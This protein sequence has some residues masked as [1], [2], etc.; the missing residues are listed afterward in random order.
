MNIF[1]CSGQDNDAAKANSRYVVGLVTNNPNGMKNVEGFREAMTRIGYAEGRNIEYRYSGEPTQGQALDDTLRRLVEER[2]DLIFTAGSPTGVAA[3]RITQGTDIPVVF[4]VIADPIRAGVMT[5]LD[6]PGGNLTGVMLSPSHSRRLELL[7]E[8]NPKIRRV[9]I[10][11]NPEDSAPASAFGYLETA[12]VQ[13]GIEIV[14]G[15]A[16]DQDEVSALF[17]SMPDDIDAI[18]LLPDSTVNRRQQDFID[19]AIARKI[20]VSG[21]SIVQVEKGALISYG[22]VHKEAGAQA[23]STADQILRGAHPGDLPVQTAEFYLGIN[24]RTAQA[25]DLDV[26]YDILQ[27][28]HTI[29]RADTQP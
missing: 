3:H 29:V 7:L 20:A 19:L 24:L 28:A 5:D 27:R 15:R 4:G 21:P 12:A 9:Y 13:L 16:V 17:G 10:P 2:V 25:I 11:F 1:A 6:R 8:I 18:F 14:A 26:P 23:A 22:I